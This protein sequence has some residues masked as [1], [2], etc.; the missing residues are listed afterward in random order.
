MVASRAAARRCERCKVLVSGPESG[1]IHPAAIT[2]CTLRPRLNERE[3]TMADC[4]L[5]G[6]L[7]TVVAGRKNDGDPVKPTYYLEAWVVL[8]IVLVA[9]VI[10]RMSRR[11]G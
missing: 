7:C 6:I 11:K 5:G 9:F 4:N 3:R 1:Y 8:P 10:G 2:C